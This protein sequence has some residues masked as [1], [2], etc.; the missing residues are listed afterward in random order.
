MPGGHSRCPRGSAGRSTPNRSVRRG[1][2]EPDSRGPRVVPGGVR[3]GLQRSRVGKPGVEVVVS[4]ARLTRERSLRRIVSWS[5]DS[6]VRGRRTTPHKRSAGPQLEWHEIVVTVEGEAPTRHEGPRTILELGHTRGRVAAERAALLAERFRAVA[7]ALTEE[8]LDPR[9]RHAYADAIED[10]W[11][12]L[13]RPGVQQ[14]TRIAMHFLDAL[15][16]AAHLRLGREIRRAVAR[17]VSGWHLDESDHAALA[18]ADDRLLGLLRAAGRASVDQCWEWALYFDYEPA[19]W[20]QKWFSVAH[21]SKAV[22]LGLQGWM[23]ALDAFDRGPHTKRGTGGMKWTHLTSVLKDMGLWAASA[24]QL[25]AQW[26]LWN[27]EGIRNA[28]FGPAQRQ[29]AAGH[30]VVV[31]LPPRRQGKSPGRNGTR[32]GS[33]ARSSSR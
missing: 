14:S 31:A 3:D 32:V 26:Q 28:L 8:D 30:D 13:V 27:R 19:E 16:R 7:K 20:A 23:M 11:F 18:R 6:R 33:R 25:R 5:T 1:E 10:A 17:D 24:A 15:R 9:Q 22:S 4:C 21:S 12:A 2:E 29:Q